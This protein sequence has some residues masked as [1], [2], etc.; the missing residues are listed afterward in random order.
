MTIDA[1]DGG[2]VARLAVKIAV[3]VHVEVE[4]AIAALHPAREVDVFEVNRLGEF[5]WIVVRDLRVAEVEQIAFAIV[6]LVD[7]IQRRQ[8]KEAT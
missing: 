8:R 6:L 4:V 5:L 1:G 3:A 7:V 2:R